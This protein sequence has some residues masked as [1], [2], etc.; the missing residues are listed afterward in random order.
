[1][2]AAADRIGRR[3]PRRAPVWRWLL[4]ALGFAAVTALLFLIVR[5]PETAAPTALPAPGP[6]LLEVGLARLED[7]E[8]EPRFDTEM[9]TYRGDVYAALEARY[10]AR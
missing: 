6:R 8:A 3:E 5:A 4:G 9:R 7:E 1:V 2:L 10:G